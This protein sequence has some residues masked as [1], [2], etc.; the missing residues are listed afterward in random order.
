M[1]FAYLLKFSFNLIIPI[2]VNVYD[3]LVITDILRAIVASHFKPAAG[4]HIARD[5][6]VLS[7]VGTNMVQ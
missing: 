5:I 2:R 4:E 3:L 7:V 6:L 1:P